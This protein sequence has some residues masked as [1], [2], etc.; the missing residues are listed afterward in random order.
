MKKLIAKKPIQYG[1]RMYTPGEPVPAH[2]QRMVKAWLAAGT[3]EWKDTAAST[4][5]SADT[6]TPGLE[7]EGW[8]VI[9][10]LLDMG[11]VL[12]DGN[13]AFVGAENLVDQ[14][15]AAFAPQEPAKTDETDGEG[16]G[17]ANPQ[18]T[19][20]GGQ[21]PPQGAENGLGDQET[22]TGHLD[23]AELEKT[24]TREALNDMAIKMGLDISECKN[25]GDVA[26]MI[27]A[28]PVQAPASENN[29]VAQ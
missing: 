23:A 19:T 25:K 4:A 15:R 26:R 16:K 12:S 7:N 21:E 1:G 2:D 11:V 20:Q 8:K 5:P 22:V 29:G 9:N 3:A 6:P 13:G 10:A 17:T 27:A 24:M 14:L 18:N 28:V